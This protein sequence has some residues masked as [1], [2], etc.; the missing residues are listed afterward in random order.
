M[1]QVL[2]PVTQPMAWVSPRDIAGVAAGR[3]LSGEWRG[4]GVQAVHGPADLSWQQVAR[5]VA[6]ALGRP[7]DVE[8]IPEEAMRGTLE[9]FGMSAAQID[10]L[11]G[12]STGF[13][14]DF[15]PEQPRSVHSTTPTTLAE[16][17]YAELK[18][19]V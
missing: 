5:I 12:M 19:R 16:W 4:Q 17:A 7:L 8:Q 13:L 11:V 18:P 3:L 9:T 2:L 6:Q 1:L 15:T 10:S 14:G